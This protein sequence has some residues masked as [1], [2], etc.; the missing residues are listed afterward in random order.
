M[1]PLDNIKWERFCQNIVRGVNKNGQKFTQ[2]AAYIASGYN[3]KGAGERGGSAEVN[4]SKLLNRSKIEN[5]IAELLAEA[6]NGLVRKRRYDIETIS[7]RIA[8][9]S[10]IAEEDRNPSALTNAER[11]I[12]EVRG[13]IIKNVNVNSDAI[14]FNQANSMQDIGRKLLQ[15]VGFASPDDASIQAAIEANDIFVERLEAIRNA[16]Q[17]LMIDQ[18]EE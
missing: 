2:G 4:A 8:L 16:A 13:L 14:D 1:P 9:A 7:E 12:A 5:R 15:S 3:A 10:R 17:G 6:Q 11:A 18:D